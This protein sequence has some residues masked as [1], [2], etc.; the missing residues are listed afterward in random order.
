MVFPKTT[1]MNVCCGIRRNNSKARVLCDT[2]RPL[3][4]VKSVL[5]QCCVFTF[6]NPHHICCISD[7]FFDENC[8]GKFFQRGEAG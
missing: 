5:T 1:T 2:S 6:H 3:D 8:D 4:E 7:V